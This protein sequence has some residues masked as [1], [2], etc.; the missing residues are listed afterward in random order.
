[1]RARFIA[2]AFAACA[3]AAWLFQLGEWL[4]TGRW[5]AQPVSAWLLYSGIGVPAANSLNGRILRDTV[6]DFPAPFALFGL[7][8]LLWL[9]GDKLQE[10]T[11]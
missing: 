7:A 1:M 5:I 8:V 4:F 10:T 2:L 6:L 3:G 11:A 9:L